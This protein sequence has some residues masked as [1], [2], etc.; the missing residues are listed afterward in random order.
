MA[1]VYVFPQTRQRLVRGSVA[2]GG[3]CWEGM[4]PLEGCIVSA[5]AVAD[6]FGVDIPWRYST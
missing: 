6:T 1:P 2:R 3:C 5:I 4:V